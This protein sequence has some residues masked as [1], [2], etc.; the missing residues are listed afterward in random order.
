MRSLKIV[1]WRLDVAFGKGKAGCT[2]YACTTCP[3]NSK[4]DPDLFGGSIADEPDAGICTNESC[5]RA[6]QEIC[7]KDLEKFVDKAAKE[8]KREDVP[9]TETSLSHLVPPHVKPSTAVRKAKKVIE[10]EKSSSNGTGSA[11]SPAAAV[12]RTP[13]EIAQEKLGQADGKWKRNAIEAVKVA[14]DQDASGQRIM[15]LAL[16]EFL[17]WKDFNSWNADTLAKEDLDQLKLVAAGNLVALAKRAI[18]ADGWSNHVFDDFEWNVDAVN[19]FADE[20]KL[21]LPPRPK[22]EDFLKP[23]TAKPATKAKGKKAKKSEEGAGDDDADEGG[24][25]RCR[26]CGCTEED[27]HDYIERT[28]K[29]CHWVEPNL[30]S[31]CLTLPVITNQIADRSGRKLN[32]SELER[33]DASQLLAAGVDAPEIQAIEW[34]NVPWI[35]VGQVEL[36]DRFCWKL[37]QLVK[38]GK[39]SKVALTWTGDEA[40][41]RAVAGRFQ[42][43]VVSFSKQRM[44]IGGD[45]DTIYVDV[46]EG[47]AVA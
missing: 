26:V 22:L 47:K 13:E 20:W 1:P 24:A 30:C 8:V 37:I 42:G 39:R 41:R 17:N 11:S 18:K 36:S 19:I 12:K 5:F 38:I 2:G 23:A 10:P 31:A 35:N 40:R 33:K 14:V 16:I 21:Q 9:V 34:D 43:I 46:A 27:C 7:E 6:K 29:P 45:Q 28:G 3:F 15:A 4:S 44:L 25:A 32:L